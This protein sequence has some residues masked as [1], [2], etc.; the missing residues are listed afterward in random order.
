MGMGELAVQLAN[1]TPIGNIHYQTRATKMTVSKEGGPVT[2][3]AT[4]AGSAATLEYQSDFI[5]VAADPVGASYLLD[6]SAITGIG[7][8][9]F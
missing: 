9:L 4:T 2:V 6:E 8:K 5:I 3:A 7:Y 1:K